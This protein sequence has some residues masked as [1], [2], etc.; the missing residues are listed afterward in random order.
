MTEI[1]RNS[2]LVEMGIDEYAEVKVEKPTAKK[3]KS[4]KKPKDKE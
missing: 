4:K 1:T 3:A 2:D